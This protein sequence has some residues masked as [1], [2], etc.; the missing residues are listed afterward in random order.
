M[1]ALAFLG[2]AGLIVFLIVFGVI[3]HAWPL[4]AVCVTALGLFGV[5]AW[6]T[7]RN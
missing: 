1:A 6:T 4:V 3:M 2:M 7:T 5:M